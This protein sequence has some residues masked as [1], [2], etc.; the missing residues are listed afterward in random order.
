MLLFM[1]MILGTDIDQIL[2]ME[3]KAAVAFVEA[4]GGTAYDYGMDLLAKGEIDDASAYFKHLSG[5]LTGEEKFKYLYGKAWLHWVK[6]ECEEALRVAD[7]ILFNSRNELLIARSHYLLSMIHGLW[8][9]Y[10]KAEGNVKDALALYR[11]L[12][13]KGGIQRCYVRLSTIYHLSGENRKAEKYMDMARKITPKRPVSKARNLDAA[14]FKAF[15]DRDYARAILACIKAIEA[16]GD[17]SVLS[18]AWHQARIGICHAMLGDY[19]EA[20]KYADAVEQ[21]GV[22]EYQKPLHYFNSLTWI[23]LARCRG[24]G[25]QT[26]MDEF[27][28]WADKQP[29]KDYYKSLLKD[30]TKKPCPEGLR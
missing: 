8:G 4:K 3:P 13:K 24:N 7:Y 17:K 23:M 10:T 30:V 6:D 1:C 12:G 29:E 26:L 11:K 9:Q 18:V 22:T 15:D 16:W 19:N 27:S 14:A 2:K 28:A 5:G 21:S 25:Y 20:Y